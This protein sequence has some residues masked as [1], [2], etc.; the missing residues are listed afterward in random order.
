MT[1]AQRAKQFASGFDPLSGY[2]E[3]LRET[4]RVHIPHAEL[5][6]DRKAELDYILREVAPGK[7]I[8]VIFYKNGGYLKQTGMIAKIDCQSKILTVVDRDIP[9][10]DIYDIE[11]IP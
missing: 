9:I 2:K 11:I 5:T 8:T 6:E 1:N 7:M 3:A 10:N 4:E